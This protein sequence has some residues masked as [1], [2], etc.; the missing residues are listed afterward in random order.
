MVKQDTT[1]TS[2]REP[3]RRIFPYTITNEAIL[4]EILEYCA[5]MKL[6]S[7]AP[8]LYDVGLIFKVLRRP[9]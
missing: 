8:I 1:K 5:L 4:T 3:Y 6:S 7:I 2:F 9:I